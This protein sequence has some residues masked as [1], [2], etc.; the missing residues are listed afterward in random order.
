MPI[1]E[2]RL[3]LLLPKRLKESLAEAARRKGLSIGEYVRQLIGAELRQT[4]R[5]KRGTYF[6][7]GEKPIHTGRKQGSV[8]HDRVG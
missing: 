2:D 3:Q 8:E 1:S 6:P 4:K 7:F 5:G